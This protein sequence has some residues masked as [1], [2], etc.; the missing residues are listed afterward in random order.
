L[1]GRNIGIKM[2]E[3]KIGKKQ[4][5]AE[6]ASVDLHNQQNIFPQIILKFQMDSAL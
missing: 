1:G 6:K 5:Q 3:G 2:M 4:C